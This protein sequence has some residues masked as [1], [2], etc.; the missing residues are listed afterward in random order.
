MAA[1]PLRRVFDILRSKSS[2]GWSGSARGGPDRPLPRSVWTE[3]DFERIEWHDSKIHG[4][5]NQL[6]EGRLLFDLDYHVKWVHP[7]PSEVFMRTSISPAT[8]VF[9]SVRAIAGDADLDLPDEFQGIDRGVEC[10]RALWESVQPTPPDWFLDG[11]GFSMAIWC[12]GFT[13][14]LR[15]AP[16]LRTNCFLR[17]AERG[18]VCFDEVG[19]TQYA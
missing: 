2:I 7:Q 11:I 5:M 19:Y 12:D 18:G 4:Y 13:Q 1:D 9:H 6:D 8:L 3:E 17:I 10:P 15:R 16:V 14:Y